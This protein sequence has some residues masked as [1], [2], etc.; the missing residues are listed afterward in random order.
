LN[1]GGGLPFQFVQFFLIDKDD[2]RTKWILRW[3][4]HAIGFFVVMNMHGQW[5]DTENMKPIPHHP[6][7][8]FI[9]PS[10]PPSNIANLYHNLFPY[11]S[12]GGIKNKDAIQD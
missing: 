11:R 3:D 4:P 9:E 7:N 8:F 10:I 6:L 1:G 2:G 5:I 12:K